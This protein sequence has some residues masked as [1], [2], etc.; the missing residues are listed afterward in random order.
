MPPVF[1]VGQ[2]VHSSEFGEGTVRRIGAG[3]ALVYVYFDSIDALQ[4]ENASSLSPVGEPPPTPQ[5]AP[6][7][8]TVVGP[9][10]SACDGRRLA[11]EC[12][13]QGLPPPRMVAS[14]TF[15]LGKARQRLDAAIAS[16]RDGEGSVLVV[17]APY[18]QGKSHLGRL[19][20]ELALEHGLATMHVLID[21]QGLTLRTGT[22]VLASLFASA[23]LPPAATD[24]EHLVPGLA[25]ILRRAAASL[26]RR[27]PRELVPFQ[28]FLEDPTKWVQCEDAVEIL[29]RYLSGDVNRTVAS[30][31]LSELLGERVELAPLKMGYGTRHERH[32]RQADQLRRVTALAGLAGARGAFIVVD[33]LDHD[34]RLPDERVTGMLQHLA[35]VVLKSP[36]VLLLLVAEERPGEVQVNLRGAQ[37]LTLDELV[38]AD[39]RAVAAKVVDSFAATYPTDGLTAGFDELF[40]TMLR[41]FKREHGHQGWGPRFFVRSSVEACEAVR[42][43]ALD[44]L[45]KVGF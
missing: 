2:R 12:L 15:G 1:S 9:L 39:L 28:S 20:R 7:A 17:R 3:G 16:A 40:R 34:L 32:Q 4:G 25:T 33:E 29:E 30:A 44:S 6:S 13:R 37:D 10:L 31:T 35:A 5:P 23:L 42:E 19:G 8:P 26:P 14:W 11:I 43:R 24:T 45:A 21:G 36:I 27:L 41:Q 22:R 38:D 18:G